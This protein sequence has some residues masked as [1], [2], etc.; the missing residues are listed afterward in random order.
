MTWLELRS[1]RAFRATSGDSSKTASLP[2]R[3][4]PAITGADRAN[5]WLAEMQEGRRLVMVADF[6]GKL[7]GMG[8]LIFRFANG[9]QDAEAAN[10]ATSR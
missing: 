1:V 9:Y 6:G 3:C 10:G 2:V 5:Q 8:Q 4:R 7:V